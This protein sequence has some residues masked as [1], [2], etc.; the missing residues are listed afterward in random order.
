MTKEEAYDKHIS[1][2]MNEII[3]VC[4]Q[5][6]INTFA[7]FSIPTEEDDALA[8]TTSMPVD[9]EGDPRGARVVDRCYRVAYQGYE[10]IPPTRSMIVTRSGATVT[11]GG[12]GE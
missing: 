12:G 6:K 8:C 1:P 9:P 7:M 4:K 10:V 11:C 3:E 2:L 5:H